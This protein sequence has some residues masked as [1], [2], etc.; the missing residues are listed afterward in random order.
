MRKVI[1]GFF[2]SIDNVVQ[3]PGGPDEDPSGGFTH[4]G[5]ATSYFDETLFGFLDEQFHRAE[6]DLL[7]GRRTYEIFAAHWPYQGDE[8]GQ[9]FDRI[10]KYVV[11]SDPAGLTWRNSQALVGD[12]VETVAALKREDGPDLLIQGSASLWPALFGAGLVDRFFAITMPVLLGR[13]K[14]AL[15]PASMASN[16]T[17]IE[18]RVAATGAVVTVYEPAGPVPIGDFSPETPSAA[19]LARREKVASGDG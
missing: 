15:T 19:E 7:L 3:A 4:G 5:W 16:M 14:R 11:T 12:P 8:M 13:G 9:R 2:Q 1:G 6:Y 18:H 17:L 10:R